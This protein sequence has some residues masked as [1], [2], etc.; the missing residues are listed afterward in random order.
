MIGWLYSW[1]SGQPSVDTSRFNASDE[2]S[3]IFL[4]QK[5]RKSVGEVSL[6]VWGFHDTQFRADSDG[7]VEV[8]GGR[9]PLS[10]K[11]LPSFL[12]WINNLMEVELPKTPDHVSCYPPI[13]PEPTR[14]KDFFE[15]IQTI[16]ESNQVTFDPELRLRH[17]HGHSQ[18]EM[19]ALKH[20]AIARVPDA[21]IYP[22]DENQVV[23]LVAASIKNNVC[24]IPYGGGTNVSEALQCPQD[25]TRTIISVDMERMNRVLWIDPVNRMASIEAGAVGRNIMADLAEHGFTMGHEPDSIEFSTL[26]GWIATNA[27]GMKKNKYGNIEHLVLDIN[28]VTSTGMLKRPSV[29]PRESVGSDARKWIFGSEGNLGIITSAV[30]KLF[31]LPEV[32]RYG[33]IL[34]PS[35]G[36]G[37]AFMYDLTRAGGQPASVRL[38]D[39]LQ[40]Q[41]SMALKPASTGFH[42]LISRIQKAYVTGI[43]GFDPQK[44]VACT[45]VFEGT[46]TEV[47]QQETNLYRVAALHR[48]MKAGAENGERGYLLT[49][50]IAYIRDFAIQHFVIAE[51]FETSI[52]WSGVLAL[53]ER[54]KKRVH[55]E[56]GLRKLP[57]KPFVTCRVT[58]VYDTGAAVYFYFAYFFEG[59]EKPSEVY[60]EI[61]AA[62]RDEILLCGGA[63]SHHH[64][65][66]KLRNQFLPRIM[67][68]GALEWNQRVK[69]AVD[70]KN[71]FGC[72]NLVKQDV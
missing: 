7:T 48:G 68:P 10:G 12:P 38:V 57:G 62:A 33:S 42:S 1:F 63:L 37:V 23:S 69:E 24:L 50:N 51:S 20:G 54:V 15:E 26:G 8:T 22:K 45:L 72:G 56:H 34:F 35:F 32:Q 30:V 43:Q 27:S 58:Q 4:E 31:P 29:L 55:K 36:D 2:E 9:Y 28:V 52:P 39:N 66:G 60:A 13:I 14:N 19:Y 40:F 65:I 6:D 59:V 41:L 25:E 46:S 70:P 49:Y 44:M 3:R 21:V 11:K 67:S 47:Q 16:F 18:A 64:G 5:P 53:C 17:G 71:I 61:E